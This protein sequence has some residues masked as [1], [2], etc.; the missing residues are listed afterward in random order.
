[1][2]DDRSEIAGSLFTPAILLVTGAAFTSIFGFHMLLSVVPLYT[3][4]V[5]GGSMGAGVATA[6]FMGTTVLTQAQMPALLRRFGYRSSLAAGIALLGAPAFLYVFAGS[7]ASILAVTLVRGVGFGIIT[8]VFAALLA[9]LAPPGRR[10]EALGL[11]GISLTVPTI[12]CNALGLWLVANY[13]FAVVFVL[14]AAVPLFGV[15]S[16]LAIRSAPAPESERGA[17]FFAGLSRGPL[18]RVMLLF[19][20]MTVVAGVV[21]TFLPLAKPGAGLFSATGALLF[22]GVSVTIFRWWAG[23]HADRSGK[24]GALLLPG[25]VAAAL[26]VAALSGEGILL[27]AGALLFGAGFGLLQ[28]STLLLTMERVSKKE[29]GL[30]STLWNFAFDAGT[31]LGALT[32]GFVISVTGFSGAFYLCAALLLA[33]LV[34]I[35]LDRRWTALPESRK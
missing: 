13:G 33:T 22:F 34:I 8:V 5:G 16:A 17:G 25:L 30:G 19:C 10:G 14:G 20:S 18:L 23:R 3:S 1:V 21:L 32:F 9:E 7:V 4:E 2:D 26:G 29:Y 15:V 31:G 12:F 28:N 27:L 35:P 11:L 24:P 6:A